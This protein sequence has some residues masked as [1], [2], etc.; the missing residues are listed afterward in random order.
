V[1][2][3]RTLTGVEVGREGRKPRVWLLHEALLLHLN[4]RMLTLHHL[5]LQK[6]LLLHPLR[7][8][9]L[10]VEFEIFSMLPTPHM[11]LPS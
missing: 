2:G 4:V 7:V 8:K 10:V 11:L 3:V 6:L 9:L 5:H 1:R